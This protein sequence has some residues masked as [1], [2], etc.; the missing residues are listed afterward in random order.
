ELQRNQTLS[1]IQAVSQNQLDRLTSQV[2]QLQAHN[3]TLKA[4]LQEAENNFH[5]S[6]LTAPFPG[7][8]ADILV[9]PGAIVAAGQ[10]VI[11]LSGSEIFEAP[12]YVSNGLLKHLRLNQQL[13]ATM[14]PQSFTV[15]VK[16]ISRSANPASQLFKIL[17]SLPPE[18]NVLAGQKITI[19]IHE[20]IE[21]IYQL[22]VSAVIDDG[23][24]EPYL[25]SLSNGEIQHIP[26]RVVDFYQNHIWVTMAQKM[27][28]LTVVTDGQSGLSPQLNKPRP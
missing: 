23:I 11:V 28:E 17:L 27:G 21:N 19:S 5:E 7:E 8:V 25:Y 22:P 26:V 2:A 24:N 20:P 9:K 14:G 16:E 4:Q 15:T 12:V 1:G 13:T 10:P 18:L 3:T 6:T